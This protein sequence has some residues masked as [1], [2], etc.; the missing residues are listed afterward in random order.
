MPVCWIYF[1]KILHLRLSENSDLK[2]CSSITKPTLHAVINELFHMYYKPLI[3]CF[4]MRD[5]CITLVSHFDF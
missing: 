3:K 2:P 5:V 4:D 1:I